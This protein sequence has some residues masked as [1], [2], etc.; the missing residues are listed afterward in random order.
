MEISHSR[1]VPKS[2]ARPPLG[3]GVVQKPPP[4]SGRAPAIVIL[5]VL[6][7]APAFSPPIQPMYRRAD[8]GEDQHG[9]RGDAERIKHTLLS[10]AA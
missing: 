9:G 1:R 8:P 10:E 6:P 5:A 2:R 7:G 4:S 3:R